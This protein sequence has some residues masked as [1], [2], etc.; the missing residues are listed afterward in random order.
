MIPAAN[1]TNKL[2]IFISIEPVLKGT[3]MGGDSDGVGV[4]MHASGETSACCMK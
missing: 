4:M 3:F 2:G 1:R